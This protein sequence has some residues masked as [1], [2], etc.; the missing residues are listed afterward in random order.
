MD[1]L[2]KEKRD[3]SGFE[4]IP[5]YPGKETIIHDLEQLGWY[6]HTR[7]ACEYKALDLSNLQF[8]ILQRCQ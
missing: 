7:Q 2:S 1:K 8:I 3:W 6:I 4:G 5:E